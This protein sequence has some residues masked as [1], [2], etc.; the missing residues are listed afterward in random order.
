MV[1]ELVDLAATIRSAPGWTAKAHIAVVRE[2]FGPSDWL[3]GPG[4]DGAVVA[5]GGE[6]VIACGEAILPEFVERDPYGAGVAAVVTNLNDVAAMG[7]VPL[8]IVDTV[9]GP[10]ETCRAA[11]DGMRFA[12]DLY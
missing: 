9:V 1:R 2:V 4:D 8:A 10:P 12:S 7:A 6:E 5:V 3:R 11:L